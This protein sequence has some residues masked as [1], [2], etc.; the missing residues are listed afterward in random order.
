MAIGLEIIILAALGL[1][2]L[3]FLVY[4]VSVY[5]GLVRLKNNIKK[6]WAN[7]N[8]LLKQRSDEL[9]KLVSSVKGYMKHE[10]STLTLL[11]KAR[12]AFLSA[13]TKSDK[14]KA[15]NII[16]GALKTLFAVAENYPNLK[17]NENFIQLQNRISGIENELA[18]R[19]EFYND[20]VN[21]YNIRIQSF[22]D[23][24]VA[25]MLSYLP[26]TMFKVSEEDK[27]DV[28]IDF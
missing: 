10:K 14:A 28:K 25:R 19:R 13:K 24:I 5:N 17:A 6:S 4:L 12:T 11:T 16:S 1:I 9:P 15:D 27:K 21:T 23:M 2:L 7:I 18:D 3:A 8:V 22:P 20:S 26:E